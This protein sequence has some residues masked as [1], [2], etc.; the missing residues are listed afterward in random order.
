MYKVGLLNLS[1]H[2]HIPWRSLKV[3]SNRV[4]RFR[5]A[6]EL[7]LGRVCVSACTCECLC[8]SAGTSDGPDWV[9]I[10]SCDTSIFR[11]SLLTARWLKGRRSSGGRRSGMGKRSL[12]TA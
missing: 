6:W 9:R 8:V 12:R 7:E 5:S 1:T 2:T 4:L 3:A 10:S 11:V